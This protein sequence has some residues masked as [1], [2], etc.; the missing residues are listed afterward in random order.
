MVKSYNFQDAYK[1]SLHIELYG[2]GHLIHSS[3]SSRHTFKTFRHERPVEG[4]C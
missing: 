2:G 4:F 1:L 3:H